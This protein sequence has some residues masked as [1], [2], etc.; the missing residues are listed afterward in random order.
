MIALVVLAAALAGSAAGDVVIDDFSRIDAWQSVSSEGVTI[1]LERP[2]TAAGLCIRYDF[3]GGAGYGG[4]RRKVALELP[5]NYELHFNWRGSG[6]RNDIQ[7]KLLDASAENV[8]WTRRTMQALPHIDEAV[9]IRKRQVSFAWGPAGGGEIR[10]VAAIEIIVAAG[11]GGAGELCLSELRLRP[12]DRAT[13]M[14]APRITGSGHAP[15]A[16]QADWPE[17]TELGGLTLHWAGAAPNEYRIEAVDDG[18][19]WQGLERVIGSD[20]GTDLVRLTDAEVQALR[21]S[22]DGEPAQS[23]ELASV[24]IEPPAFGASDT[25]MLEAAA[26]R[27]PPGQYPRGLGTEQSFWTTVGF[28][29]GQYEA[30]LSE[31]GTLEIDPERVSIEPFLS[32]DGQLVTWRDALITH[33]LVDGYLPMPIVTWKSAGL[34]LEIMAFAHD[35]RDVATLYARYRVSRDRVGAH[36]RSKVQLYLALRPIQVN[37]PAQFLGRAGGAADLGKLRWDGRVL[38]LESL[39]R[40]V[41]LDTPSAFGAAT[42][43]GGEIVEHLRRGALPAAHSVEDPRMLASAAWRFDLNIEGDAPVDVVLAVPIDDHALDPA[44]A[45]RSTQALARDGIAARARVNR[46]YAETRSAWHTRL[47]AVSFRV[48]PSA[49]PIVDTLRS[50]IGYIL[51]NR[52]GPALQPGSRAYARSWIR[53]GAMTSSALLRLGLAPVVRE[54]LE[55]FAEYQFPSGKI[56]C[57]VDWRGADP[58]PEN[59]SHGE[60]LFAIAEYTRYTGDTSLAR[61]LWSRIEKTVAYLDAMRLAE[62]RDAAG[63]PD[64][65]AFSGLLAPSISHEGYVNP[66]HAYWDNYWALSGFD[67]AVELSSRLNRPE[68]TIRYRAIRDEFLGDLLTSL[69]TTI[70]RFQLDTLP[71]AAELGDFD[72]TSA[73]VALDP[74]GLELLLPRAPLERTFERY[75][76]S[77]LQRWGGTLDEVAYTP[78]EMRTIGTFVRLGWRDRA[79]RQIMEFLGVR[80]PIEW[81]QWPEVLTRD[82]RERRFIGDL[83]HTWV[84]SDYIRSVLDLFAYVRPSDQALVVAAGIPTNWLQ[85]PGGIAIGGLL[86][87]FGPLTYS[88]HA[89]GDTVHGELTIERAPPGGVVLALPDCE[90]IDSVAI[91]GHKPAGR[92]AGPLILEGTRARFILRCARRAIASTDQAY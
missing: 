75:W 37:P 31:D 90:S 70:A 58:V 78:Y 74:A 12:R 80:R 54:Y 66:V 72:P 15:I 3:H 14:V 88:L 27:A 87:P 30:L 5:D 28:D 59:D 76:Q 44:A 67:A 19:H 21:V 20:G 65:A 83:P 79:Q 10:H 51:V 8:W 24:E 61:Q 89:R 85:A 41:P 50:N 34:T 84:G 63:I 43:D 48:P 47:E 91:K 46:A 1:A 60:F 17:P 62:R 71:G 42:W 64:R 77:V 32:I 11:Q 68:A 81:N 16:W 40:I 29:G 22:F 69:A 6:P 18:G 7:I 33:R 9:R 38:E 49:Q 56:P 53:D 26:H 13:A 35:T 86:T 2:D 82:P 45:A 39:P 36:A 55:W 4:A 23:F 92:T 52:D 25:S 73:T 57:C